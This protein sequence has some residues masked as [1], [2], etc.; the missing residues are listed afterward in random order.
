[1]RVSK[2]IAIALAMAIPACIPSLHPLYTD[3]DK[4]SVFEPALVGAWEQTDRSSTW[5]FVAK[6]NN[7]YRLVYTDKEGRPGAFEARLI[8]LDQQ[9]FLDLFP[10]EPTL[11]ENAFYKV[12]L[13]RAHT[14]LRVSLDGSELLLAGM[15][16]TWLGGLLQT[17][18]AAIRHETVN[19]TIVLTAAPKELQEFVAKYA[20]DEKA[21]SAVIHLVRSAITE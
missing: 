13:L 6:D 8:K 20:N 7:A 14:F 21:F 19:H 1:M 17:K 15:N 4:D 9:M 10:E 2:L 12:H 3:K 16:P 5:E 11:S 18:P